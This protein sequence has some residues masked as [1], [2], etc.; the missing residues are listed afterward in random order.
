MSDEP[1]CRA[2]Y[3]S[4]DDFWA[5]IAFAAREMNDWPGWM[6]G[7]YSTLPRVIDDTELTLN[8]GTDDDDLGSG[9]TRDDLAG[10]VG[11]SHRENFAYSR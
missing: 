8:P 9:D 6:R 1:I 3:L 10:Q 4:K 5:L 11:D 7:D 2:S